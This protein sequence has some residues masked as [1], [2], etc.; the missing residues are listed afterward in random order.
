MLSYTCSP[1][2]AFC[3]ALWEAETQRTI[4]LPVSPVGTYCGE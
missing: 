3:Q 2:P 4:V 1:E